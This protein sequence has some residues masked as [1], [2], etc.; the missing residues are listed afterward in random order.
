MVAPFIPTNE[1]YSY[2]ASGNRR[3]SSGAIQS[4]NGILIHAI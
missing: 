1:A 4:S 2:D 3:S